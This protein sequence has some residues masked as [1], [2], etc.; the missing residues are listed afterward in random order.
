MGK[1][2]IFLFFGITNL[3]SHLDSLYKRNEF[4]K[5]VREGEEIT[6]QPNW[7]KGL[8][9]EKK[10]EV[11]KILAFSSVAIGAKES[12]K[13]YFRSILEILPNFFLDSL[14]TSPKIL[15]VFLEAKEGFKKREIDKPCPMPVIYFYPGLAQ[16]KE[17]KKGKGYSLFSFTTFSTVGFL[18]TTFLTPIYHRSYLEKRIPSEISAAYDSYKKVY[19]AKQV[20]GLG[21]AFSYGIHLLDIGLTPRARNKSMQ[22]PSH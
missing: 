9:R 15:R 16:L 14:T 19:I 22:F 1:D 20:F 21:V 10:V 4:E 5:V 11:L 8:K 13:E 7:D 18:I 17:G 12:A 2:L 3:L 6:A